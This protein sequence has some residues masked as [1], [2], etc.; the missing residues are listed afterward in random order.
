MMRNDKLLQSRD[1]CY[2]GWYLITAIII[3]TPRITKQINPA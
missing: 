1:T 2:T 3:T